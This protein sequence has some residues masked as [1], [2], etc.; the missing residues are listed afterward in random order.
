MPASAAPRRVVV[1]AGAGPRGVGILERIARNLPELASGVGVDIH[2]VDPH[3]PGGGRIWRS[4][5]SGLLKLNSMAQDVTMFTDARST[6]EGPIAPGPSLAEWA[7]GIRGG[8]IVDVDLGPELRAEADVLAGPDFPTR[9]LQSAYL[10]WFFRRAVLS[11]PP[12]VTVTTHATTVDRVE[13]D[14]SEGDERVVLGTGRIIDADLVLYAL[15]HVESEPGP[16]H[17]ELAA[18]ADRHALTYLAPSY[19][20]DADTRR[21]A[22]GQDVIVRGMGLAAV[23]LV[24]L[25]TEGRGGAFEP[26]EAGLVY[27]PSGREPRLFLGSRRGVPYHSKISSSTVLP[28]GDA[29]YFSAEIAKG[30]ATA[31]RRI[32]LRDDV[33]PLIAKEALWAYYRELFLGHPER[34]TLAWEE[35]L[36]GFDPLDWDSP[37]L[38]DLVERSVPSA[39]DRL[40]F[41]FLDRPLA[42]VVF[43]DAEALQHHL[44]DYIRTDLHQR[45]APEHSATLALFTSLLYSLFT[46]GGIIDS[47]PWTARS[48]AHE[49]DDW[50]MN[51]FSF[52]ASGPPA[53]RLDELLALSEAGVVRFLG[54]DLSVAVE[55]GR[56][57]VARSDSVPGEIIASAL[58]D[59][60]LPPSD[61]TRTSNPAIRSL[62]DSG[63]GSVE[64]VSDEDY[65]GT[66]GRLRVSRADS[67]V[68]DAEGRAH[69]RR[70]AV[71]A[72]TS[73]PF[74]G[75]F[76]RPGTDA[77]SFREN[78][79]VARALLRQ[80]VEA[81]GAARRSA[82]REGRPTTVQPIS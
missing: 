10:D 14:R 24:V 5:Q 37:E 51:L 25:L 41:S 36:R 61:V 53:H 8:D 3:P 1:I 71:G 69:P 19:T 65:S 42:G 47:A 76:S 82:V 55:P 58:V 31:H 70:F 56:G 52:I 28:R 27:R 74:V 17:R 68:I 33:W 39:I 12:E 46:L 11:L 40:D 43:A 66:T 16:E 9:R 48:R 59:A 45:S 44:R 29:R 75:A 49:F 78:D 18:V 77:V 20:A 6:I 57:F 35:F 32:S 26:T 62:L 21:L 72:Y 50:W 15:G 67:R 7:E 30:M 79:R 63:I 81:D 2:L 4:A 38:R 34:V 73:A 13:G 54:G 80:L 23:D 60:R 64:V 22:P